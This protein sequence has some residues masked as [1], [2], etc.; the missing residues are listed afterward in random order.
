VEIMK[1]LNL[2]NPKMMDVAIP[3]N[4]DCGQLSTPARQQG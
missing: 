3:A 2:P 1:K 4:L